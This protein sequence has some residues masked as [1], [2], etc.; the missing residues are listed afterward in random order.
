V[1]VVC[2]LGKKTMV[3][4]SPCPLCPDNCRGHEELEP[5]VIPKDEWVQF[6]AI[7]EGE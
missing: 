6:I 7:E 4:L 1:N 5:N 2:R 3:Y